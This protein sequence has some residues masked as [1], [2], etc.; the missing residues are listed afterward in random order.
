MDILTRINGNGMEY[1]LELP[2][3]VI[4]ESYINEVALEWMLK[5]TGLNFV[6]T[7][8]NYEAQPQQAW[9][10]V[11]LITM[12]SYKVNFYDNGTFKNTLFLKHDHHVGYKVDSICKSCAEHNHIHWGN[13]P[14]NGRLAS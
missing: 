9:Q 3:I 5:Q 4:Q 1:K 2:K 6:K 10:I 8:W 12:Y 11:S 7:A 13:I 14:D